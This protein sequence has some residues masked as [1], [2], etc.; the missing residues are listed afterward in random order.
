M[1]WGMAR[2]REPTSKSPSALDRHRPPG[3]TLRGPHPCA[4]GPAAGP[5]PARRTYAMSPTGLLEL[6]C[7]HAGR[8]QMKYIVR[9]AHE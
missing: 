2:T 9:S 7:L 3:H 5:C 6:S 8:Q 1:M 4:Y